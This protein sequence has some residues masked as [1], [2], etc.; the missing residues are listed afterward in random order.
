MIEN[1]TENVKILER[2]VYWNEV[3]RK[4]LAMTEHEN[5]KNAKILVM[6]ESMSKEK[7]K[8]AR[9]VECESEKILE[10]NYLTMVENWVGLQTEIVVVA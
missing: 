7:V 4:R 10:M 3:K 5:Q 6:V 1:E 2:V 9:M 8:I